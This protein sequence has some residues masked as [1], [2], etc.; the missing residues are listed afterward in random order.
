[1]L[2][3]LKLYFNWTKN[4]ANGFSQSNNFD[5]PIQPVVTELERSEQEQTK[6]TEASIASPTGAETQLQLGHNC[7]QQ[8]QLTAAIEHYRAAVAANPMWVEPYSY[9]A[10]ALSKAG[11]LAESAACYRQAIELTQQQSNANETTLTKNNNQNDLSDESE[12]KLSDTVIF[13]I[14]TQTNEQVQEYW[15]RAKQTYEQ[16]QWTKTIGYCQALLNLQPTA[17]AY[18]LLGNAL[19]QSQRLSEALTAYTS[20]L[21]LAPNSAESYANLG[22][23][24][25]LQ[26]HWQ[27]A[28]THY[29]QAIA[30]NPDFA[31]AYRNLAKV[32]AA[33]NQ[34]TKA[35]ECWHRALM[36]EPETVPAEEH[37]NF[38]NW[39]L[40]QNRTA[41]AIVCYRH[42]IQLCPLLAN[43]LNELA[44]VCNDLRSLVT[45][46]SAPT[47]FGE[48]ETHLEEAENY[49]QQ[50]QWDEAIAASTEALK[51]LEPDLAQT[52][53]HLASAFYAKDDLAIA[54][55]YYQRVVELEPQSA[56]NQTNL[57][58]LYAQQQHWQAAISCYEQAIALNPDLASAH[59]NLARVWEQLEQPEAAADAFFRALTLEPS[60]VTLQEHLALCHTLRS[61]GKE[62]AIDCYQQVLQRD[63]TCTAA[64]AALAELLAQRG[65]WQMVVA[66]YRWAIQSEPHNVSY[67]TGLGQALAELQQGQLAIAVYRQV[68]TLDPQPSHYRTLAQWLEQ[69]GL[70]QEAIDCYQTL[71]TLQPNDWQVHHKLGDLLNQQQCWQEAA[72]A[73]QRA[74]VL[75]PS[76]SWL[77]NS[78]GDAFLQLQQWQQAAAAYR[79]AIVLNPDF[80]WSHYNL[81]EALTALQE[82]DEAINA[83]R[84]AEQLQP[85]IAGIQQKLGNVLW[86]RVQLDT[87]AAFECFQQA[88]QQN[89]EDLASYHKA[90]EIQ[91]HCPELYVELADALVRSGKAEGAI[92]FYQ[93]AQQLTPHNLE[94][95]RK[96]ESTLSEYNIDVDGFEDKA[97]QSQAEFVNFYASSID[98]N[99]SSQDSVALE[100]SI[101]L[102]QPDRSSHEVDVVICVHNALDDV[103]T[104]LESV[105]RHNTIDYRVI[106]VDDGSNADTQQFLENWVKQVPLAKLLRNQTALGY[107]QAANVG[108]SASHGDYIVLLNSDTVVTP[109][110]INKLLECANSDEAI[111][112]VGP[113]SNCATWQSVPEI[114]D[115]KGDWKNN[116][117]PSGYSLEEWSQLI[118]V[119]SE[120]SFPRVSFINGFCYLIKRKV[121]EAIGLLDEIHFPY[122][123]GEENDFSL[124]AQAAGFKL[125]IADHAYVY[126]AKSKSFGPELR[127]KL[128]QQGTIALK[129]KYHHVNINAL[130]EEIQHNQ[131]LK[132][133]RLKLLKYYQLTYTSN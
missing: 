121:I 43:A 53:R 8:N 62:T 29:Q 16:E 70:W 26:Q 131:S 101:L 103:K 18:N 126:H 89:P 40:N 58:S 102:D 80:H 27:E 17:S 132:S 59:W 67:L 90:I 10:E 46:N 65:Q 6:L 37:L 2:K 83:Y 117:L 85:T 24:Y 95:V 123:Y 97:I 96:L 15:C 125:A 133:L 60:W 113:L 57:G 88:I 111:G 45:V 35:T 69:Q 30:L 92:V 129:Q 49:L 99:H 52:Y 72:L 33:L 91:P 75:N 73:F 66:H 104:C 110:W 39:L 78:L 64:H 21:Q 20:A 98:R 81:A 32:W 42:A 9:L 115:Y 23:L 112:I 76:I 54:I 106:V 116:A 128:C 86:Q 114:Q 41:E 55:R 77:H 108:L 11:N 14:N 31:G 109:N 4:K 56:A 93:I 19:Q 25:A 124:R 1:M 118:E 38:G 100:D 61:Q 50:E 127:Q 44:I 7:F 36:L 120:R 47:C 71:S 130:T 87:T 48:T 74:I 63:K 12:C 34:A 122:G 79:Q 5:S 119:L 82:W 107:T 84:R 22:S 13:P 51:Q 3:Q 28:A 68:V 105:L 94:I